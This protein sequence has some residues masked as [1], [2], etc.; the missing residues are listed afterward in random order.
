MALSL[1]IGLDA[2]TSIGVW[3]IEWHAIAEFVDN[4]TQSYFI[5]RS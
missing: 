4:A 1:E 2:I 3:P 5:A